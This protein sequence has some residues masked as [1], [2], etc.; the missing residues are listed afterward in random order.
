MKIVIVFVL[1]GILYC[2]ASGVYY[3]IHSGE[4]PRK[5]AKALTW[6]VSL[7]LALFAFLLISYFV[8]W[9]TPH[10]IYVGPPSQ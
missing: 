5:L 7:S 4:K 3:L 8:G 2:L 9:L 1:L 10:M 6:R